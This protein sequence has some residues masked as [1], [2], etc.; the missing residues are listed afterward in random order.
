MDTGMSLA[1]YMNLFGNG[2]VQTS[3]MLNTEAQF[4]APAYNPRSGIPTTLGVNTALNTAGSD[5]AAGGIDPQMMGLISMA[6]QMGAAI[7]GP[8]TWQGRLG[9]AAANMG[10]QKLTQLANQ[11]AE[12]RQ[13]AFYKDLFAGKT[14][15]QI[16]A[17]KSDIMQGTKS[18]VGDPTNLLSATP[19]STTTPL[20]TGFDPAKWQPSMMRR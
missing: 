12:K 15:T 5:A 1:P 14:P 3:P 18:P 2:N 17:L 19:A 7:A 16:E 10:S 11:E 4:Q 20:S 13:M 8:D 6:G 9:G